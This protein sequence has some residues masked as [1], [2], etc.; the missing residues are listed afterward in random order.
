MS[1][2]AW[3]TTGG[4]GSGAYFQ[5]VE[6]TTNWIMVTDIIDMKDTSSAYPT[7][8]ISIYKNGVLRDTVALNQY[9][10]VPAATSAPYRIGTRDNNSYFE[11]AI[12]KVAVY[13]YALSATQITNH[14][15]AM[16]AP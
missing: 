7:G 9:S 12:G 10:V 1:D 13:N 16:S 2:Y 5:D 14:Y 6:T 15:A 4:L 8:Y 11:G 3:N